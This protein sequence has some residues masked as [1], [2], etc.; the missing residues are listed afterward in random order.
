M[1]K[2]ETVQIKSGDN[3]LTINKFVKSGERETDYGK[4][5]WFM[6]DT[7]QG[8][9]FA[10]YSVHKQLEPMMKEGH[11][12]FNI[13]KSG[14]GKETRYQVIPL[15]AEGV[16][17][18]VDNS[19]V[20]WDAKDRMNIWQTSMQTAGRIYTGTKIDQKTFQDYV[21][22]LYMAGLAVRFGLKVK[23]KPAEKE[24][25]PQA[26]FIKDLEADQGAIMDNSDPKPE[27]VPQ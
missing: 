11:R 2:K 10:K 1:D 23:Y 12:K 14:E 25:D 7:D 18:K 9:Y 17:E 13:Q 4:Q 20:D 15:T 3:T 22:Q 21:R 19:G 26:E 6:Y 16:K 27:E 5:S 8:T 24:V